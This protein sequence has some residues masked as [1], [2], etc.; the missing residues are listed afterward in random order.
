[1]NLVEAEEI[2]A[3]ASAL[4]ELLTRSDMITIHTPLKKD[5]KEMLNEDTITKTKAA[6]IGAA[7]LP[8]ITLA[9]RSVGVGNSIEKRMLSLILQPTTSTSLFSF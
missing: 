1:M 2:G 4:E 5:T 7:W 9:A 3:T 8:S 6:Q